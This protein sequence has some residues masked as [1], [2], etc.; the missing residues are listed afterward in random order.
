MAIFRIWIFGSLTLENLMEDGP[1]RESRAFKWLMAGRILSLVNLLQIP[2]EIEIFW[3]FL[4]IML[5][6]E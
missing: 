6:L 1:T 4:T 2:L 3:V 5:S